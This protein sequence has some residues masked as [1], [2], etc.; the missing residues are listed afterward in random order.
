MEHKFWNHIKEVLTFCY[1]KTQSFLHF[2]WLFYP[3]MILVFWKILVPCVMQIFQTLTKFL[4]WYFKN[5]LISP[6]ISS[7]KSLSIGKLLS[8]WWLIQVFQNLIFTWNFKFY[9]WQQILSAVFLE[10]IGSFSSFLRKCLPNTKVWIT[11]VF[12]LFF[13]VKVVFHE[14]KEKKKESERLVLLQL[15]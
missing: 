1:V 8:L 13:Q 3:S 6:V 14:K 7:E 10:A 11:T 5:P 4:I 9:L 15:K 2:E 12:E